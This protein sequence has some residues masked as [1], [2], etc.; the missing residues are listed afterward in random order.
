MMG[1]KLR[2]PTVKSRRPPAPKAQAEEYQQMDPFTRRKT[3][4]IMFTGPKIDSVHKRVDAELDA[5][6]GCESK[7]EDQPV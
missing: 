1:R 2:H 5:R 6:Y 3:R 4:P 7:P